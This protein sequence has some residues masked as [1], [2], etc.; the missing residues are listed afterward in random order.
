[1]GY[2]HGFGELGNRL[3]DLFRSGAPDFE[4]AEELIAQGADVNSI[5]SDDGASILSEILEGYWYSEYGDEYEDLYYSDEIER[6]KSLNPDLGISM[7]KI[8]EFFLAHGFD[9]SKQGGRFGAHC[10]WSLTL[11]TFDRYIIDATKLLL[12]AGAANLSIAQSGSKHETPK[13][14]IGLEESY[15]AT[16]ENNFALSNIYEA[17]WQIYEAIENGRPYSGIGS[18]EA[19]V[20]KRITRVLAEGKAGETVFYS[21]RLPEFAKD[22]CFKK[23]LY[24]VY[25]GGAMIIDEYAAL[26]VN[27][28]LPDTELVDVSGFFPGIVGH[29]LE[30][31]IFDSLTITKE[32]TDYTKP[33]VLIETSSGHKL[34]FS[35]NFGEV[36]EED[37]AAYFE[38]VG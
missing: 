6:S 31:F 21:L 16:C 29:S 20:G 3:I 4:K 12:D 2:D 33:I 35:I 32:E 8:I 13:E 30:R 19:A 37:R 38:L 24:F 26:W 28:V 23:T 27:S 1:M 11:S 17:V 15:Q 14:F 7:C 25:D 34:R 22:S 5:G 36:E 10:L 9:V 18:Y